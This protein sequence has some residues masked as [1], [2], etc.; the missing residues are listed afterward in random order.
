MIS[1]EKGNIF[2]KLVFLLSVLGI[3]T[4]IHL[5][6]MNERGFDQGCFGFETSQQVE[7]TFDC[8]SVIEEGLVFLGMSNIF[9]GFIFYTALMLTSLL[10]VIISNKNKI[11]FIFY[12]NLLILL[13]FSYSAY[14]AYYQ[15]F[16]LEEY[17]ALCL[18]SGLISAI[19][20]ILL[21]LSKFNNNNPKNKNDL[22]PFF[23]FVLTFG[24]LIAGI[25]YY[26]FNFINKKSEEIVNNENNKS[27]DIEH[28]CSFNDKK[29]FV[30]NYMDLISDFD[31][32]YG[33]PNSENV[34]I[35]IFDPNCTHCK[36]LH[37]EMN[38]IIE[39]YKNDIFIIIK[40]NPLWNHSLQ[41][42]QALYIAQEFGKFNEMLNE[43]FKRQKP[44]SGLNLNQ[45]KE[46]A[47]LI[48]MD[49]QILSQ[50]IK[51]ADYLNQIIQE[52][53]KVRKFGIT[54]APTL[55]LNGKTIAS[56]SRNTSCIGE[57]LD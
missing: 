15:H 47:T 33:N 48:D 24:L 16:I 17:C 23:I 9:W 56:K 29:P 43:Q 20:F 22:K 5:Y 52:N 45:L 21:I 37:I 11:N 35:E 38:N 6:I 49:P 26:Y 54:S 42:I 3:L 41:Q 19:L 13:G 32:K 7:D 40:P 30:K 14:L 10:S 27:T 39:A 8:E 28:Q 57:L 25:D 36:K 12:R 53:Q 18:I 4:T 31:I 1:T 2:H 34:I 50:R 55:L 46:I 44:G 51:K